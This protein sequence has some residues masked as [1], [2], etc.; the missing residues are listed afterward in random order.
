[1]K[2]PFTE[3]DEYFDYLKFKFQGKSE[4]DTFCIDTKG[5]S[6][7]SVKRLIKKIY[8][9]P[10]SLR[11][12]KQDENQIVIKI[13]AVDCNNFSEYLRKKL[14]NKEKGDT[15]IINTFG[16]DMKS[17]RATLK[18]IYKDKLTTRDN[19]DG[20]LS[21]TLAGESN[22]TSLNYTDYLK[23]KFRDKKSGDVF[24]V[25]KRGKST[26]S[27]RASIKY[28]FKNKVSVR[29]DLEDEDVLWVKI[30]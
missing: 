30:L 11:H 16:K 14:K 18:Y 27:V 7:Q 20:T 8:Q 26:N 1:M 23:A 10:I 9:N 19:N 24:P 13:M 4:G 15:F 17:V 25:D 3:N 29:T 2:S 22:L 28:A 21:I 6:L 12:S 5:R